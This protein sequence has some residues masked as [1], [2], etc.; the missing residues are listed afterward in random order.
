MEQNPSG[1]L[2]GLQLVK[3]FL[4]F[5]GTRRFIIAF[6]K[7]PTP[8]TILSQNKPVRAPT[9]HFMKIRLNI[10]FHLSLGLPIGSFSQ[11]S[12]LKPCIRLSSHPYMQHVPPISF[13]LIW[14]PNNI[15]WAVL[16]IKLF[17]MWFYPLSCYLVS[18]RPKYSPQHR[19][20][21]HP[22][23][24]FLTQC[25]HQVAHP[26]KTAGKIIVLYILIFIFLNRKPEAIRFCTE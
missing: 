20:I 13:F 24:T 2:T 14:S 25:E 4:A 6:H 11:V 17:I 8:V 1:K 16:T 21:I 22:L 19:Y 3:K 23:P 15:G 7:C 12:P 9:S 26:Y 18:L 5:Y 10:I